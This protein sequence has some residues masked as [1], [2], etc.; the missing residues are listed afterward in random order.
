MK[1]VG[2]KSSNF[3]CTVPKFGHFDKNDGK[4]NK[5]QIW[6]HFRI[7]WTIPHAMNVIRTESDNI[8]S[9]DKGKTETWR[10]IGPLFGRFWNRFR[11]KSKKA[12]LAWKFRL[13]A[14][15]WL[16][17]RCVMKCKSAENFWDKRS[18]SCEFMFRHRKK[19][20]FSLF[21]QQ[22]RKNGTTVCSDIRLFRK[23]RF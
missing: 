23:R 6:T 14:S 13:L 3:F 20:M 11:Y 22:S 12:K 17:K 5:T 19:R 1:L 21:H 15:I 2:R 8:S 10:K 4:S 16:Q 18:T 9:R 7:H